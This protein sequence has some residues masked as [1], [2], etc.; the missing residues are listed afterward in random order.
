M[1][2]GITDSQLTAA[3]KAWRFKS[4]FFPAPQEL[5]DLLKVDSKNK[6]LLEWSAITQNTGNSP[7]TGLSDVGRR[8]LQA[9]GGRWAVSNEPAGVVRK[10]FLETYEAFAKAETSNQ[11]KA[12]A[13][14]LAIEAGGHGQNV[15]DIAS[16]G[17]KL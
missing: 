6:A 16:I 9:I 5:L 13:E 7:T 17:R 12:E 1:T 10:R 14:S 3:A 2:K 15:I 11:I 4:R 8:A